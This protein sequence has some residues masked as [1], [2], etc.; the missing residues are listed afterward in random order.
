MK[1]TF[2]SLANC[3]IL[4][5]LALG[6]VCLPVPAR[7][8]TADDV[9]KENPNIRKGYMGPELFG[10][11]YDGNTNRVRRRLED[12]ADFT[13]PNNQWRSALHTAAHRGYPCKINGNSA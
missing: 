4:F 12:K 1:R 11:A 3:L 6:L 10:A 13:Y 7:A 5:A 9:G 8:E 2:I